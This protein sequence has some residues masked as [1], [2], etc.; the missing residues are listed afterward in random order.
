MPHDYLQVRYLHA[1]KVNVSSDVDYQ[2][3][4][5]FQGVVLTPKTAASVRHRR[6]CG[7]RR[8]A[9]NILVFVQLRFTFC[10][11]KKKN[12]GNDVFPA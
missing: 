4:T 7:D 9:I 1:E 3:L 10:Y 11:L 8:F 12:S 2:L 6:R 5:L